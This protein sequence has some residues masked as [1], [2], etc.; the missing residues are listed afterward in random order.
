M[1]ECRKCGSNLVVGKN[2]AQGSFNNSDYICRPC[3]YINTRKNKFKNPN[4]KEWDKKYNNSPKAKQS[5]IKYSTQWG[6]GV[7]GIFE[8]G[9]CLY[10]GE[11]STLKKRIDVHL[12][13]IKKPKSFIK[14]PF[15]Y[16]LYNN[17][18]KHNPV[19]GILEETPNHKEREQYYINK[20]KPKYNA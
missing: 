3:N 16:T 6:S 11:S 15:Y 14:K 13:G 4:R 17:I 19:I 2:I 8:N 1:K 12:Y 9:K 10:V 20:L 7:Y 18:N 5:Y